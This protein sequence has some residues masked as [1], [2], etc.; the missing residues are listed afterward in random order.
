[1]SK[2]KNHIIPLRL[3]EKCEE[4]GIFEPGI[5]KDQ[6]WKW[7]RNPK[8]GV[9]N[10]WWDV[11][12]NQEEYGLKY[13][14]APTYR[15]LKKY[16][17]DN[18]GVEIFLELPEGSN[19]YQAVVKWV[20][21]GAFRSSTFI[22]ISETKE[23]GIEL[24]VTRVIYRWEEMFPK[25]T[26]EKKKG[27]DL[28]SKIISIPK[29]YEIDWE[30]TTEEVIILTPKITFNAIEN[31][32][33]QNPEIEEKIETH[34][35]A[36]RKLFSLALWMNSKFPKDESIPEYYTIYIDEETDGNGSLLKVKKVNNPIGSISFRSEELAHTAISIL[37]EEII[38][39]AII[40][41]Q[42]LYKW[43]LNKMF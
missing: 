1:M 37:G 31:E 38:Y 15:Q 12:D 29:G 36:Y 18:Y 43:I 39:K 17:E 6:G 30:K 19:T 9:K 27:I 21:D 24:S 3:I 7:W 33:L 23:A 26:E 42:S 28:E 4:L 20:T 32:I 2:K 10:A 14:P 5:P 22:K 35:E 34:L 8:P 41:F 13:L 16:L 11:V 40:P 25:K